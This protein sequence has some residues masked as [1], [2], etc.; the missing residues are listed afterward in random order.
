LIEGAWAIPEALQ[1]DESIRALARARTAAETAWRSSASDLAALQADPSRTPREALRDGLAAA[2][3][4]HAKAGAELDKA[5]RLALDR[6]DKLLG[7]IE[8][9]I[10]PKDESERAL[11]REI[12]QHVA[13]LPR[14]Q[15]S[16]FLMT[17]AEDPSVA[18]AILSGPGF[19]SKLDDKATGLARSLYQTAH[20]GGTLALVNEIE[21]GAELLSNAAAILTEQRTRMANSLEQVTSED[22]QIRTLARTRDSRGR[23][24]LQK[25]LSA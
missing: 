8:S 6:R 1:P 9:S 21:R 11:F 22:E 4:H 7:E 2:D 14:D 18:R 17:N 20:H 12:R 23:S 10:P 5:S 19:L 13:S 3:N 24:K 25:A 15:V 16:E